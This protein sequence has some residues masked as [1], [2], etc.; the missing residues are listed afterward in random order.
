MAGGLIDE[1][2]RRLENLFEAV[3]DLPEDERLAILDRETAG[4]PELRRT[5]DGLI[6]HAGA[7]GQRIA[8]A[9]DSM[10]DLAARRGVCQGRRFGPYRIVREIGRGGMGMVFEAVRDDREYQ[11][12]VALKIAPGL[13]G[14]DFLQERFRHERQ[15]LAGLEHPNIARLLDG[16]THDGLP[17][18]TMEY[19]EGRTITDYCRA[20]V[21]GLR[22]RIELFRQVCAAVHYA[23]ERLV[24][25]S[26]LK[27]ANI[28]V[29]ERAGPEASVA[30]VKLLDFG[31]ARLLTPPAPENTPTAVMLWTPDYTSPEQAR[32]QEVTTRTD[33]YS[34]GLI[35]YEI[36]SGERAQTADT[37][38][39]LALD[40]SICD[41]VPP[42]PSVRSG[43]RQL[44]GDLD[45]IVATAIC[46]EPVRRYGSVADLSAD[47]RRYLDGLPV[48]ARHGTLAYRAGKLV[49]RHR[50]AAAAVL[51]VIAS[52]AAG[53]GSTI[54]Q[55]LRAERRFEQVRKLSNIFLFDFEKAIHDVPGTTAARQLVIT[56]GLTYLEGLAAEARGD[57]QLVREVARGYLR[58]AEL[59][60]PGGMGTIGDTGGAVDSARRAVELLRS[61]QATDARDGSLRG[62]YIRALAGLARLQ[63]SVRDLKAAGANLN[64]AVRVGDQWRRIQPRSRQALETSAEAY[65]IRANVNR[66]TDAPAAGRDAQQ[67][68]ALW[69]ELLRQY[70]SDESIEKSLASAY[71]A[72]ARVW[73]AE[74]RWTEAEP[75]ARRGI[76]F[77]D[78]ILARHAQDASMAR[79]RAILGQVFAEA[80]FTKAD[81]EAKREAIAHLRQA[82][83]AFEQIYQVDPQNPQALSDVGASYNSLGIYLT[84]FGQAR[85]GEP[86]L[87]KSLAMAEQV[88]QRDPA[89][90]NNKRGVAVGLISLAVSR[91]AQRD[92]AGA[93]FLRRRGGAIY[94]ELV[95]AIPNDYLMLYPHAHNRLML[96]ALLAE[97]GDRAGAERFFAQVLDVRQAIPPGSEPAWLRDLEK[98]VA[99]KRARA[100]SGVPCKG[101]DC[102]K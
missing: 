28:L 42:P 6:A 71:L 57:S 43:N 23:H 8:S 80:L 74:D 41:A 11:K 76:E 70:P 88:C 3:I 17:Y 22:A 61:V 2:W 24:V 1:R 40:R 44:A 59:Q 73:R 91:Q 82:V 92:L 75:A 86:Y 47:L 81:S 97:S 35:L 54:Y 102:L 33:V 19:V 31:I 16:G 45:M 87:A 98:G 46:K 77:L 79:M 49:R 64:E 37:S 72:A 95:A 26:D 30:R 94:D 53:I 78:R 60:G 51:L 36:L 21:P 93:I 83:R 9:V 99:E 58:M 50:V 10:A 68:V 100:A 90:R 5:L 65:G 4:D 18:F 32:G 89:N 63:Y 101:E 7:A 13:R 27:P 55:A 67:S 96:G 48:Q 56:H 52:V 29:E 38:S 84:L 25:H 69:E 20:A 62:D 39:P 66:S 15:I 34:L 85:E 14:L 12:T